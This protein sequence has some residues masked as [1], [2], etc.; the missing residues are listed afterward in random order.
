MTQEKSSVCTLKKY[1]Y[2]FIWLRWVL[3]ATRGV[4]V[5]SPWDLW[6]WP[7]DSLVAART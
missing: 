2:A 3:V 1:I 7:T 5:A 4:F 6:F